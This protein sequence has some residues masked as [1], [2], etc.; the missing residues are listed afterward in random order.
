MS[1]Q[2]YVNVLIL[3]LKR[4]ITTKPS[5]KLHVGQIWL[6]CS[7]G[8][9]RTWAARTVRETSR[10]P[11]S[12]TASQHTRYTVIRQNWAAPLTAAR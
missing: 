9:D 1:C 10:S 2:M 6:E 4:R 5:K 3:S 11:G 8:S 12:V 7:F